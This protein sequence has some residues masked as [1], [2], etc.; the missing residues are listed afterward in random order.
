L[1]FPKPLSPRFVKRNLTRVGIPDRRPAD[2]ARAKKAKIHPARPARA[3]QEPLDQRMTR[4]LQLIALAKYLANV[5][6]QRVHALKDFFVHEYLSCAVE[7][8]N[9]T[10]LKLPLSLVTLSTVYRYEKYIGQNVCALCMHLG[11]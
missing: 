5:F 7:V 9:A 4:R 8:R 1:R 10:M 2:R 3:N 11:K 6:T